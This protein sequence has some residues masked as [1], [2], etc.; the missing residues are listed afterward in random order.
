MTTQDFVTQL[1]A[2][3][4]VE[5]TQIEI[6][7][8]EDAQSI[9]LG[10]QDQDSGL[11]IGRHA[12]TIDSLQRVVRLVCQKD[13]DKPIHININDFRERREERVRELARHA[14]ERA[15]ETGYPQML[16]LPANERRIVHM[17]LVSMPE[18]ETISEG[19]GAQRVLY[20]KPKAAP[21]A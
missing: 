10:V 3:M 1:L 19:E 20:V 4:G 17:E 7:D 2:H 14:A 11:L 12:E 18:V 6:V 15:L 16:R 21:T 5:D 8:Q 9:N 13:G